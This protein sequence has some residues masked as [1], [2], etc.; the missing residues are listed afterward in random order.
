MWDWTENALLPSLYNLPSYFYTGKAPKF[1]E[2]ESGLVVGVARLRQHRA[3]KGKRCT[4]QSTQKLTNLVTLKPVESVSISFGSN[5]VT[6]AQGNLLQAILQGCETEL[7]TILAELIA[8][9]EGGGVSYYLCFGNT[10]SLR[11]RS[12]LRVES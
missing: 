11:K 8:G 6:C 1:M 2:G 9:E 5:L 4:L 7:F 10:G 3:K 12:L